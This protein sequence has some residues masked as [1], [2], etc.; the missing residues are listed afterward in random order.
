MK[1]IIAALD[2]LKYSESVV[3]YAVYLA[4][5]NSSHLVGVFLEDFTYHSYHSEVPVATRIKE[6]K[7]TGYAIL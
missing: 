2:G 1:K 7:D 5:Q 3:K 4:K 6:T